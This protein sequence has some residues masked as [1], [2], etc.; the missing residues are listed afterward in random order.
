MRAIP[1]RREKNGQQVKGCSPLSR[2]PPRSLTPELI[3][4]T[5]ERNA[6]IPMRQPHSA[7]TA[8]ATGILWRP[9]APS[10]LIGGLKDM[11]YTKKRR[12]SILPALMSGCR[13]G[14]CLQ[15]VIPSP[16]QLDKRQPLSTPK[17]YRPVFAGH[18]HSCPPSALASPDS[19]APAVASRYQ[20][21]PPSSRP[22]CRLP[23]SIG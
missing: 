12:R 18:A 3:H 17:V 1:L 14:H 11:G 7:A 21:L 6:F 13:A 20:L 22:H 23:L 15:L 16:S 10:S 4:T 2:T 19:P 8:P 9:L 5:H